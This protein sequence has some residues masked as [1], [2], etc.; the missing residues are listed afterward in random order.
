MIELLFA[1]D[2]STDDMA[3]KM[4]TDH[5]CYSFFV[6]KHTHEGDYLESIG[7]EK[8]GT[9]RCNCRPSQVES[10]KT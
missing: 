4:P 8:L 9:L 7:K 5:P 1:G 10:I 6:F 3:S 2:A